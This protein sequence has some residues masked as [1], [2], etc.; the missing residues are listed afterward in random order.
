MLEIFVYDKSHETPEYPITKQE[1]RVF[2]I[3]FILFT[4]HISKV[5]YWNNLKNPWIDISLEM[6]SLPRW[7]LGF[8]A[9]AQHFIIFA[10]NLSLNT[11]SGEISSLTLTCRPSSSTWPT[12]TVQHLSADIFSAATALWSIQTANGAP[13][14]ETI[15]IVKRAEQSEGTLHC[16]HL[17][18]NVQRYILW[19][20]LLLANQLDYHNWRTCVIL[21]PM[22]ASEYSESV[23]HWIFLSVT[24]QPN[25]GSWPPPWNF[26]FRFDY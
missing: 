15:L 12:A 1:R 16:R 4:A 21:F 19:V 10:Q 23:S 2:R 5:I 22:R 13:R 26:P 20:T 17:T 6:Y 25:F 11:Q 7:I 24:L 3:S 9:G 18:I 14:Q 8:L